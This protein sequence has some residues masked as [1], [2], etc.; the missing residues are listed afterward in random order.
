MEYVRSVI[1]HPGAIW[2]FVAVLM[3]WALWSAVQAKRATMRLTRSLDQARIRISQET[4]ALQFAERFE[5][6]S[7]D[8]LKLPYVRQRWRQ[9]RETLVVPTTPGRP[10]R[11]TAQAEQWF[12][13]SLCADAGLGQRYHAALPNLLV[14][15]GLL[16][17]F[18]GL[19]VA[20][21]A[22]GGVVA[23]GIILVRSS[24]MPRCMDCWKRRPSSLSLLCS[25]LDCRSRTPS[26][27]DRL[28]YGGLTMRS[29]AF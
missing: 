1:V 29:V 4:D 8:L 2:G 20:L 23:E 26:F 16:F 7:S 14:G 24:V 3:V 21:D 22:A 15:A 28:A 25:A 10:I 5:A 18:A 13:L 11:A 19:T 9:Y 27:G 17:T 6:V 12:D